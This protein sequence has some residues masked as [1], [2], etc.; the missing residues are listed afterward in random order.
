MCARAHARGTWANALTATG[1]MVRPGP[2]KLGL[3]PTRPLVSEGIHYIYAL[4]SG[5]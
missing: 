2:A 1:L 5:V 3:S 4:D